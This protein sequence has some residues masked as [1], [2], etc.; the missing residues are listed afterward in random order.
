[1]PKTLVQRSK[2]EAAESPAVWLCVYNAIKHVKHLEANRRSFSRNK[3][4]IRKKHSEYKK[5]NRE[6][7]NKDQQ[8]LRKRKKDDSFVPKERKRGVDTKKAKMKQKERR[9]K[10]KDHVKTYAHDYYLEHKDVVLQRT[11]KRNKAH[12]GTGSQHD[13]AT[14][15][16]DRVNAAFKFSA[17]NKD[18][19][20]IEL[21]GCTFNEYMGFLGPDTASMKELDLVIDH[22]WPV[23]SFDLSLPGESLKAFNFKNTRLCT[24][25]DNLQ[26]GNAP[27]STEL[28]ATVPAHLW[29]NGWEDYDRLFG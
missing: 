8:D 20:T 4:A 1:M 7:M 2:E 18:K 16:R 5:Q 15:C 13:I 24:R 12:R 19:K 6:K 27:P 28:R 10:N 21:L 9:E 25:A 11:A 3:N 22:I 14:R 23:A 26:K 29:P 17:V